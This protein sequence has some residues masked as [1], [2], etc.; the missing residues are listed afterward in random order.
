MLW[1]RMA[2]VLKAINHNLQR[3]KE[4]LNFSPNPQE[5]KQTNK[6]ITNRYFANMLMAYN[7]FAEKIKI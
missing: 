7:A 5:D 1:L 6:H 4:K 3:G 2:F